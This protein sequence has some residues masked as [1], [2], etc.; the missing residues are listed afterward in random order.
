LAAFIA[1]RSAAIFKPFSNEMNFH[2]HYLP[3]ETFAWH[4]TSSLTPKILEAS[5]SLNEPDDGSSIDI[6]RALGSISE[7]ET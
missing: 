2:Y 4:P 7:A 3:T 6:F 5:Y 1:L